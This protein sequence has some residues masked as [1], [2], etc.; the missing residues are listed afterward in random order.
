M[1]VIDA[2]QN[3]KPISA[4]GKCTITWYEKNKKRTEAPDIQLRFV[5]PYNVYFAGSI[6]GQESF[7]VGLNDN[8]FWYRVK[9]T[10]QFYYGGRIYAQRCR[11]NHLINPATLL[12]ALGIVSVDDSWEFSKGHYEDILTKKNDKG[13]PVKKIYINQCSY[14]ISRVEYYEDGDMPLVTTV[15]GDYTETDG[16]T[17]PTQIDIMSHDLDGV[18]VEIRL[19]GVKLF[20]PTSTQLNGKLFKMPSMDGYENIYKLTDNCTFVRE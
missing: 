7:R 6:L 18:S 12:E 15:L 10:S 4:S 1:A 17:V 9:P 2:N 19:R 3:I 11:N 14:R 16:L 13:K 5:P 8:Q 20:E